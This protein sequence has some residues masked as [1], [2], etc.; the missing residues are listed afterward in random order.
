M[1]NWFDIETPSLHF[2]RKMSRLLKKL[3]GRKLTIDDISVV[4]VKDRHGTSYEARRS[5]DGGWTVYRMYT[6]SYEKTQQLMYEKVTDT[7][8]VGQALEVLSTICPVTQMKNT[9]SYNHPAQ[10]ARLLPPVPA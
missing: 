6:T 5:I 7:E 1:N 4:Q 8:T 10:I 3:S 2:R 9:G